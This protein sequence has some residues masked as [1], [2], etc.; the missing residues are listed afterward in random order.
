MWKVADN[1][2]QGVNFHGGNMRFVY[3]PIAHP[4]DRFIA[5]PEYY[6]M[7]AFKYSA[8]GQTIIPAEMDN[9]GYN[10]SAHAVINHKKGYSVTLINKEISTSAIFTINFSRSIENV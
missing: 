6:A 8:V 10:I 4:D 2:G 1:G 5:Q 9:H 3:S 7:L